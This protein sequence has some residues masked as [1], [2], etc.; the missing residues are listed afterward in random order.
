MSRIKFVS[1]LLAISVTFA[2]LPQSANAAGYI[3]CQKNQTITIGS[4]S[5]TYCSIAK[6][7][8]PIVVA[9]AA[10]G[11]TLAPGALLAITA[12]GTTTVAGV[13]AANNA[14]VGVLQQPVSSL[15][16]AAN[17]VG[18]W[19]QS[20]YIVVPAPAQGTRGFQHACESRNSAC[21]ATL[22]EETIRDEAEKAK[23]NEKNDLDIFVA[24]NGS[25]G[26]KIAY[27]VSGLLSG[28]KILYG[29]YVGTNP[30]AQG[31]PTTPGAAISFGIERSIHNLRIN[32]CFPW[33]IAR[34]KG[35]DPQY[36]P[37]GI[38]SGKATCRKLGN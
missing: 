21:T 28:G 19:L 32:G 17:V 31:V 2:S 33:Q 37:K 29:L 5:I 24:T 22:I 34:V 26:W 18:Q 30:D 8:G 6:I 7:V 4:F 15:D 12:G 9:A 23:N 27:T 16:E 35:Y 14:P 38:S 10:S 25:G 3:K 20:G 11:G 36:E 13:Y 1:F